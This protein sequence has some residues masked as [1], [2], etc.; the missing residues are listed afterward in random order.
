MLGLSAI[1]LGQFVVRGTEMSSGLTRWAEQLLITAEFSGCAKLGT[2]PKG[3]TGSEPSARDHDG[4][5]QGA[6]MG[7]RHS[8]GFRINGRGGLG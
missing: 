4:R 2:L 7:E 5:W 1:N 8:S 3:H 6:R